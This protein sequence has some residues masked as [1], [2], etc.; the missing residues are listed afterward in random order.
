MFLYNTVG[1]TLSEV[2]KDCV[3]NKYGYCVFVLQD[4]NDK[5]GKELDDGISIGLILK[6]HPQYAN[7]KIKDTDI[8]RAKKYSSRKRAKNA[9]KTLFEK[10]T[11]YVFEVEEI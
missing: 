9:A 2:H 8:T 6:K 11:N 7:Y 1:K 3:C 4:K 5:T 10:I